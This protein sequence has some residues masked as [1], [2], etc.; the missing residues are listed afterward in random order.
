MY[1]PGAREPTGLHETRRTPA[2]PEL[3]KYALFPDD[4]VR[5]QVQTILR[6]NGTTDT[7][8]ANQALLDLKSADQKRSDK[9]LEWLGPNPPE[10]ARRVALARADAKQRQ[11]V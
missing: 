9:A 11:A 4:Y 10:E 8:L 6:N 5:G 2:E 3:L 7:T 1:N